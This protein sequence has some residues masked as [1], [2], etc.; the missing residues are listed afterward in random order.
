MTEAAKGV[1]TR[2]IGWPGTRILLF[3]G[4]SAIMLFNAM[5]IKSIWIGIPASLIA[6]YIGSAATGDL[7]FHKEKRYLKQILGVAAFLMAITLLGISLMFVAMFTEILSLAS[8]IV[9]GVVLCLLAALR[10]PTSP[11]DMLKRTAGSGNRKREPYLLVAVFLFAIGVAFYALALGRTGEGVVSVWLT[12]P[13]MFLPLFFLSSLC[14]LI[15]VFF[16]SIRVEVK[17]ALISLYSFLS[18]SLFLIIWYPGRYGDP[19]SHLGEARFISNTGTIY[20]YDWL[21]SQQLIIDFVKYKTQYSLVVFLERMFS[22]DI[23]WVH[24]FLIPVLWSIFV[25]IF[26][27]K[28]ARLLTRKKG[29]IFPLL[30][31]MTASL[32]SPLIYWGAVSVPN[33][34]AFIFLF[35]TMMLLLYGIET[36]EKRIWF[37]SVL[38]SIT[39]FFAHP[40]VGIFAFAFVLG[41][42]VLQSKLHNI[43]KAIILAPI[44]IAYPIV[45]YVQGAGFSMAALLNLENALS[46]WSDITTLLAIFAFLGLVYSLKGTL[47]NGKKATMLFMFYV[48]AALS[49]FV[50][51]YG[52]KDAFVPDRI[53]PLMAILLVP[54]A[55]L[56]LIVVAKH[57]SVGLSRVKRDSWMKSLRPRAVALLIVCLFLSFQA[58]SALYETYPRQEITEVQPTAY[59]VDAVNYIDSTAPGRYV[60][61]GDTNLATIASGFLGVDYTYGG[62][63]R[64]MFG[65]PR[66]DWWSMKLYS[67]MGREPSLSVMEE[68]MIK[69]GRGVGYFVVSVRDPSYISIVQRTSAVMPIEKVFGGGKLTVF[70][71]VSALQPIEGDGPN[72][73]VA[74]DDGTSTLVKTNYGYF[75][76]SE[77]SYGITLSGHSSYK[78]MDYPSLWTFRVLLVNGDERQLD[79]STDVNTL[80]YVTDLNPSDVVEVG[81]LA[82]EHYQSAGWKEDSFRYDWQRHPLYVGTIQPN[83]ATDGNVLTLS[84]DFTTNSSAYQYYYHTKEANV[85]TDDYPY[86][87]VRW[88]ST[89]PIATVAVAYKGSEGNQYEIVPYSSGSSDWTV[90]IVK[91]EPSREL[92]YVMV[93]IT[94]LRSRGITGDLEFYV[95]YILVCASE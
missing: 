9:L 64:G 41:A 11:P 49:Y 63:A 66:W 82:N 40:Q 75:V 38:T 87:L 54:F 24:V 84:W 4:S 51:M 65:I 16:N 81:W 56:G 57:L 60:V 72:V 95:D 50:S 45:S 22:M 68:A 80:I 85:S 7:C 88:K 71:H 77:V 73:Q 25:P 18:H 74:F 33:S 48:I 91:M 94:N 15:I 6:V 59:E 39:A 3:L 86:I 21:V 14:L 32:F 83:I 69:A 2:I 26:S 35:F 76:K 78:I 90:T 31:A 55:S 36:R 52:M 42:A 1:T 93:G 30:T 61:L 53:L 67:K 62:G 20:A 37:L 44:S 29:R 43:L 19:W 47:V 8:F 27:Y 58:T 70:K 5:I 28:L 17:L 10:R 92:A 12:I 79:S 13:S 89:G 46:F 23:Y 34:L